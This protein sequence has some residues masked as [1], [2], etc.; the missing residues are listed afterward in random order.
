MSRN[1]NLQQ[2]I[3]IIATVMVQKD[4]DCFL[5]KRLDL[6]GS[7]LVVLQLIRAS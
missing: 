2:T 7:D 6:F 1:Y 5:A 3:A 4:L